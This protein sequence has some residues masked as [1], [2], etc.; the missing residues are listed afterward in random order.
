MQAICYR[1]RIM[2]FTSDPRFPVAVAASP[3]HG[4]RRGSARANMIVLHYT[5]M[6]SADAALERLCSAGAEVSAHYFIHEDGR[7]I[8]SVPESRRAWHAGAS[9]WEG[10]AD[11]N[12]RSIGIE[13]ANPGHEHGYPDFPARQIEAA[14]ALCAD[15]VARLDIRANR[16]LGHSDIAPLRKQDPGEKFPWGLLHARGVGHW[17]PPTPL[18]LDGPSF[19]PG[20]TGPA[21]ASLQEAL[22]AYGYGID[23]T[24]AFDATTGAIVRAFQQHFRQPKVDGIADPSTCDTLRRLLTT[25][26]NRLSL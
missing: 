14:I 23:V 1:L 18:E 20:D 26:D 4:E 11:N 25:R 17:V 5:G 13:I 22:L 19:G 9:L 12:S 3:N 24:G 8:Q 10:I 6:T 15:I 2:T 21:V 16:I 7:I